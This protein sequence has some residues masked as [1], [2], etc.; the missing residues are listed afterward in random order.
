MKEYF[1]H[2]FKENKIVTQEALDKVTI[3]TYTSGRAIE[4][5]EIILFAFAKHNQN[6]ITLICLHEEELD[7][8]EYVQSPTESIPEVKLKQV[9]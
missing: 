2:Q 5:G 9:I 4:P 6:D 1:E 3:K 7:Q 8:F